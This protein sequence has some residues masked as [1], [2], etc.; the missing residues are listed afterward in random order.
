[1]AWQSIENPMNQLFYTS[2]TE[3][4]R[5]IREGELSARAVTVAHLE[6][7]EQVN[8][9]LNAVVQL[10]AARALDAAEAADAALER[11]ERVGPLHGVPF[12]IKDWIETAGVVCAA[13]EESRR[14]YL[15]QADATVVARLRR[16]GGIFLGK[17]NVTI[18]NP[19]YGRTNNPYNLAYSPA[20]SSSGEAAII[21]A[22]GSPLGLGSD[23]GGSI[24]Q[25]AHNCGIAGLKPTTGRV[26]LTGHYPYISPL[27]DPRTVI[28]PMARTV[29]DLALALPI[30]A[31]VD[32]HDSSVIPMPLGDWQHVELTGLR[33]VFYTHHAEAEPSPETTAVVHKAAKALAGAGLQVT[34][35]VPPRIHEAYAI[36][37]DYWR[38]PESTRL[39]EWA[40][41]GEPVLDSLAVEKHLFEWERFRRG[42]I[43][44]MQEVDLILT[45]VAELPAQ[46]HNAPE[47]RIPYTL[48]YSLTGYPAV[49]VRAGTAPDGMP[50]G[51]QLVARPWREDVALAAAQ[52]LETIF[53]GWQPPPVMSSS[54]VTNPPG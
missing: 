18:S 22:G 11:G 12:T 31:G 48:P 47:G 1:M 15:P 53:G 38:R 7:I 14:A 34:E 13:G 50:I 25:P 41:D 52:R 2:A 54:W 23:S 20:G 10:V 45:P 19:V 5:R 51:V 42:M 39:D 27:N 4:A 32:W 17:T 33:M 8:P 28:G 35:T 16:A 29:A 9:H 3:L 24:R 40:P 21:A 46:P 26:P 37:R 6:R 36:T 44:F 30:I 43:A 49:V